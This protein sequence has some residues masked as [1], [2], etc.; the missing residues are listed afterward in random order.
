MEACTFTK[1]REGTAENHCQRFICI[2]W[3]LK[4]GIPVSVLTNLKAKG[5]LE[6]LVVLGQGE[7]AIERVC[8]IATGVGKQ[9]LGP[10]GGSQT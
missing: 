2:P 4:Q 9:C 1:A 5:W 10:E 3:H 8:Y 6:W 7:S